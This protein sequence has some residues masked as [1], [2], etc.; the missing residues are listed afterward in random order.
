MVCI[1]VG[2]HLSDLKSSQRTLN[3]KPTVLARRKA[4]SKR[5]L[6]KIV[7]KAQ[8]SRARLLPIYSEISCIFS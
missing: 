5:V 1:G 4:T 7:Q 6:R 2:Q 3:E 8:V